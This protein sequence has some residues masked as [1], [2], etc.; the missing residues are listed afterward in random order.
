MT[1]RAV[2]VVVVVGA[3]VVAAAATGATAGNPTCSSATARRLVNQHH[4]NGFSLPD[5][6]AQVLCGAFTGTGSNAMAITIRAPTCWPVQNWV[7]FSLVRGSWTLILNQPGYL[8]PPLVALGSDIRE[9]T[10]VVQHGDPRCVPSGGS[11]A[12]IWH[13]DGEQLA[14]GA[15]K[16]V[17]PAVATAAAAGT[18]TVE[19][20]WFKTPSGNIECGY[21]YGEG[22][23]SLQCGIKSGL[24]PPPPRRGPT[25]AQS[26]RVILGAT[27]RPAT[28]RSICPG[29]DESDAGPFAGE[30]AARVLGYGHMWTHGGIRCTS[31]FGGLTCRNESRHGFFLSRAR[32]RAF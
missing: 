5:P 7:V 23:T 27:G 6:V 22:P 20:G 15:W 28:G 16:Q 24:K 14:A 25:C 12:R 13:W 26:N 10:A 17:K 8:V 18:G 30:A 3:T 2:V 4:L 19:Y 29:E 9:T 11:H 32:W 21:E 1:L 31:A